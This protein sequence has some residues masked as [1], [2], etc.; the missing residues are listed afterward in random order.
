M[1]VWFVAVLMISCA[2][3]TWAAAAAPTN[4]GTRSPAAQGCRPVMIPTASTVQ[5]FRDCPS[6]PQ[7][8]PLRG[9][10]FS[11]GDQVGDGQPYELPAHQVSVSPFALGRF[12]VTAA[13]WKACQ[14][15]GACTE[16]ADPADER[17]GAY[18]VAGV[19]WVQAEAYAEWLAK[20]TG[21][22]YRLPSEAEWEYAARAGDSGRYPWASVD[23]ACQRANLLDVSGS[24]V[25]PEWYWFE[26][27]DD[28]FA[29]SAPV[30]SFPPNAWGFHDM[31]GNVWEWVA[32]CWHPDYSGAPS[33]SIAWT[34]TPCRKHVN[35]GGGWGNNQRSLRFS[36]RDA[37][38]ATARSDSLGF[39]IARDLSQEEISRYGHSAADAAPAVHVE[40]ASRGGRGN[41]PVAAVAPPPV[42]AAAQ[43]RD[44]VVHITIHG[45]QTWQKPP[46][47]AVGVTEQEVTL[48]TR[49]RSDGGLYADNLL[50]ADPTTRFAIKQR[51]YA[52]QGLLQITA[53]NGGKLPSQPEE[54]QRLADQVEAGLS[55]C[56]ANSQCAPE[57]VYR[58]AAVEALRNDTLRDIQELVRPPGNGA[59][60]LRVFRVPE[61]YPRHQSHACHR[62]AFDT[63]R[64]LADGALGG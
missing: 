31:L 7:L 39:R 24:N 58:S 63:Q 18:P 9:G 21:K 10:I 36:N 2:V 26:R 34:A 29:S 27:C 45:R 61:Q 46:Q 49:L 6:A 15:A 4:T 5:V 48:R 59:A 40:A 64:R 28:H 8:I 19:S 33:T 50:D 44:F 54:I 25:H 22:P 60:A 56:M 13:E 1:K 20:L 43:E 35:R 38:P 11:M 12:E 3:T 37:D 52:R 23:E 55:D 62:R 51:Y 53:E 42:L 30:G 32:D 16:S 57:I 14:E 17:H 41:A 47:H